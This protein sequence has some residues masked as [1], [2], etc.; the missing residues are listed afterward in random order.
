VAGP[1]PRGRPLRSALAWLLVIAETAALAVSVAFALRN[2]ISTTVPFGEFQTTSVGSVVVW[3]ATEA[4]QFFNDLATDQPLPKDL[5]SG[6]S[7]QGT[8]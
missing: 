3:N 8:A 2:P 7:L 4:T 6:T 1:E 5:I